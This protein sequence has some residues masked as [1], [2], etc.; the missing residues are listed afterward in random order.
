MEK[1]PLTGACFLYSIIISLEF[2]M[3]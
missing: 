2:K 1:W 3:Q